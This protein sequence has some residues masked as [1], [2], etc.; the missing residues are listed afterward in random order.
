MFSICTSISLFG[1]TFSRTAF[2][3]SAAFE[4]CTAQNVVFRSLFF[5]G[6]LKLVDTRNYGNYEEVIYKRVVT[7]RRKT[8]VVNTIWSQTR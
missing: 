1:G 8:V 3:R 4:C 7:K 6:N 5:K 2:K